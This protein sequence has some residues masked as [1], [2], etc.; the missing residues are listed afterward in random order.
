V[1]ASRSLDKLDRLFLGHGFAAILP[2]SLGQSWRQLQPHH[3]SVHYGFDSH[4][5]KILFL[6]AICKTGMRW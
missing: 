3:L 6:S 2:P 5:R 1:L 4:I